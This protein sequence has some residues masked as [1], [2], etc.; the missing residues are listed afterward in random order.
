MPLPT[1]DERSFTAARRTEHGVRSRL[2]ADAVIYEIHPQSFADS[3]AEG[4]GD[5]R[6]VI[7]HL[8]DLP[9]A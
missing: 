8:D 6:G 1:D 2:L 5:L 4:I 9:P 7:D 3:N